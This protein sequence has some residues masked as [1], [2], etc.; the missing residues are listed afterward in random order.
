VPRGGDRLP[1]V[2]S[3]APVL[4]IVIAIAGFAFGE[5]AARGTLLDELGVLSIVL[6][7]LSLADFIAAGPRFTPTGQRASEAKAHVR[8]PVRGLF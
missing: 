6:R 4:I 3:L 5:D 8:Y 1:T 7:P 2:F